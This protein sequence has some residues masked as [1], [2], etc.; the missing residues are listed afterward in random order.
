MN[1]KQTVKKMTAVAA[2]AVMLGA[3]IAGAMAL[4][5]AD[6]PA[7]LVQDGVF[8]GKIVV[9]QKA[10]TSDVLGAI[11]ISASLQAESKTDAGVSGGSV[12]IDG[13][14][15]FTEV[16]FNADF[17]TGNVS[18]TDNNLDGF[19]DT[20][21]DFNDDTIDYFDQLDLVSSALSLRTSSD[22]GEYYGDQVLM[23]VADGEITYKLYFKDNVSLASF[24]DDELEVDFLGRTLTIIDADV[25]SMTVRAANEFSMMKGDSVTVDDSKVTL[26]AVGS[27]SVR[28][29]VGGQS[30]VVSG[31]GRKERFD[32]GLEVQVQDGSIFYEEGGADNG[33]TLLIGADINDDA[34]TDEPAVAF[35]EPDNNDAEWYWD[36]YLNQS[37]PAGDQY[38][39]VYYGQSRTEVGDDFEPLALGESL[40]LPNNYAEITFAAFEERADYEDVEISLS[41]SGFNLKEDSSLSSPN[42]NDYPGVL[43]E[44]VSGEDIFKIDG[45]KTA[46]KVWVVQDAATATTTEIWYEDGTDE[47]KA[48]TTTL[49][50][51]DIDSDEIT[52]NVPD[53]SILSGD[54]TNMTEFFNMDFNSVDNVYFYANVT[55]EHFGVTDGDDESQQLYYNGNNIGTQDYDYVTTYGAVISNPDDAFGGSDDKIEMSLPQNQQKGTITITSRGSTVG[56]TSDSGAYTVNEFGLGAGVLDVDVEGDLGDYPMLVVGGPYVNSVAMELMGNPT[57]DQINSMFESGKAKIK[58]YADQNAILVAGYSAQDTLG[59]S[60]VLAKYMD[61]DLSGSEVEVLVPSLNDISV[62]EPT[63]PSMVDDIEAEAPA[64]EPEAP[65]TEPETTEDVE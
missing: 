27:A 60:Y 8:N 19:V 40:M 3:T 50:K 41:K 12:N 23:N 35:G 47:V 31:D 48:T 32:N 62:D 45:S 6:Y 38:I 44:S 21:V 28:V 39:G 13:G 1:V 53:Y 54:L 37:A 63:L 57:G 5:L 59:A 4:S 34:A 24:A 58:L 46:S 43:F 65:A 18:L 42:E 26:S 15:D 64:T 49:F 9:G 20:D 36:I 55:Q 11:D 22:M 51:I 29:T 56:G 17:E 7:P 16:A 2:G 25:D 30:K 61:Y 10:A 14:E 33:A 52:V